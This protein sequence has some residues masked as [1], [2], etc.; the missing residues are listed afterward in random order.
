MA[1]LPPR[2][3]QPPQQEAGEAAASSGAETFAASSH[4]LRFLRAPLHSVLGCV[5][6]LGSPVCGSYCRAKAETPEAWQPP[7][8]GVLWKYNLSAQVL[9][10]SLSALLLLS[11]ARPPPGERVQML[12]T[13]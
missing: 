6:E 4:N 5:S 8:T 12:L 10:I 11:P 9:S 2:D 7:P 3:P 1:V 13:V